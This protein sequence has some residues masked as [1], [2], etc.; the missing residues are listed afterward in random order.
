M[1]S[2]LRELARRGNTA[3]DRIWEFGFRIADWGRQRPESQRSEVRGQKSE[4]RWQTT[5]GRGQTTEGSWLRAADSREVTQLEKW[6][7]RKLG[8]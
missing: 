1:G 7:I 2:S 5:E 8:R 4:D 3:E 6:G